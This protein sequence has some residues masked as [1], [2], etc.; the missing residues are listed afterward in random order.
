MG[1]DKILQQWETGK[2]SSK[3]K[4]TIPP[5]STAN[6]N[7]QDD[8]LENYLPDKNQIDEKDSMKP[9]PISSHRSKWLNMEPQDTL[10]LHG[11]TEQEAQSALSGFIQSMMRRGLTE[12]ACH[13]WQGTAFPGRFSFGPHGQAVSG[14]IKPGWSVWASQ[15]T[16]R[17]EG[18]YLVLAS[19]LLTQIHQTTSLFFSFVSTDFAS[20]K[21]PSR[22]RL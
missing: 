14:R 17:R 22:Y 4:K 18:S 20:H 13:P 7:R 9:P 10:D 2:D 11:M 21:S 12:G 1:F 3:R 8:W 6:Q 16:G 15:G 19:G 5:A